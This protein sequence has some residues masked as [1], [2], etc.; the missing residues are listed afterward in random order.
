MIKIQTRVSKRHYL[1][2][3][4][5][6]EYG[7]MSV[8]IPK[9]FH[10]VLKPLLEKEFNID[11]K[12]EARAALASLGVILSEV[13]NSARSIVSTQTLKTIFTR[14]QTDTM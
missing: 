13:I 7:R 9:K 10:E 12:L 14:T 8:D 4:R 6:Y 11:V 3:K 2:A 5:T 1:R